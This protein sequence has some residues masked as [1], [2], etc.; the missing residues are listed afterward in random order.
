MVSKEA[1]G[2]VYDGVLSTEQQ[3]VWRNV[4][5]GKV[6]KFAVSLKALC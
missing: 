2:V 4:S 6:R 1:F 3:R 5:V